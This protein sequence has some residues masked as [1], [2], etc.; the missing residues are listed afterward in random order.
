MMKLRRNLSL[1]V[2][3]TGLLG[4]CL[5]GFA[6]PPVGTPQSPSGSGS[7]AAG[8]TNDGPRI[9]FETPVHDFGKIS[10][11]SVVKHTFVFTNAGN[12][13]LVIS[14]VQTS[15]GCTTAGEWTREVEPG[16]TGTIPIQ[17]SGGSFNG[18]VSKSVTVASNDKARPSVFLQIKGDIWKPIE[19]TPAYAVLNVLPDSP[20]GTTT[21]SI[22]N[23]LAA[24]VYMW[25]AESSNPAFSAILKT[26]E[27]GKS[28]Q[29]AVATVPPL[30][31]GNIQGSVTIKSSETNSPINFTVWANVQPPISVVP[32]ALNLP[33]APLPNK[34]TPIVNIINNTTNPLSLTEPSVNATGVDVQIREVQPGHYFTVVVTFPEGF[35]APEGKPLEFS[36]HSNNPKFETIK[37]PVHQ[38]A[39]PA[40]APAATPSTTT[41]PAQSSAGTNRLFVAGQR[42]VL[43][44]NA[45]P[46]VPAPALAKPAD[47][48]P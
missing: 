48:T 18:P 36:V 29:V 28:Y 17:F 38:A 2:L 26:N 4:V 15:C 45:P 31:T 7:P 25:G 19:V 5:S 43:P 14:G 21:V 34:L 1:S 9:A 13:K 40:P 12:D 47:A 23:N 30:K 3:G 35:T 42:R 16:K 11:G 27:P 10:A 39:K 24:P 37:V 32:P 33:Q 41:V 6:Q 8:S 44:P 46:P 20:G 22:T